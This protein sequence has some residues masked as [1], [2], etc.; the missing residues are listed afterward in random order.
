MFYGDMTL[1]DIFMRLL[2][3]VIGVVYE[4]PSMRIVC[5]FDEESIDVSGLTH[6][7][8]NLG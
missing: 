7:Q 2:S 8:N 4:E 1:R 3:N 5:Y 6:V